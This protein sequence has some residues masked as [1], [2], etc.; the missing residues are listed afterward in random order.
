MILEEYEHAIS[1][2][3][4]NQH[5]FPFVFTAQS[6]NQLIKMLYKYVRH[7]EYMSEYRLQDISYTLIHRRNWFNTGVG[8]KANS[9]EEFITKVRAAITLLEGQ[10]PTDEIFTTSDREV[11]TDMKNL[12]IIN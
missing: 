12:S 4:H 3:D 9:M 2:S 7:E 10:V 8:F 5:T 1:E 11:T 6:T